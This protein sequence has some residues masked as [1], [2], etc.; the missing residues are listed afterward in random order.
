MAHRIEILPDHSIKIFKD[1]ESVP[2]LHQTCFPNGDVWESAAEAQEWA[3]MF[4][5]TLEDQNA[6]LPPFGRG[7]ER[8]A[9][10]QPTE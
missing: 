10:P 3:E 4:V 8:T 5:E 2:F 7:A 6:L 1:E 9:R